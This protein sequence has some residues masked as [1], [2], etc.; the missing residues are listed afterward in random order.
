MSDKLIPTLAA[1]VERTI[2][3]AASL[4]AAGVGQSITD[5]RFPFADEGDE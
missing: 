3:G 2:T 1:P 4:D 5:F